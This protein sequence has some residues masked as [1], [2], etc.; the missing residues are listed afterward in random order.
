MVPKYRRHRPRCLL[1]I[2]IEDVPV[3][4]GRHAD[5]G[6]SEDLTDHLELDAICQHE[7][8]WVFRRLP[9]LDASGRLGLI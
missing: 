6:V 2:G 1:T 4:V 5:R 3:D 7:S 8:A 9:S